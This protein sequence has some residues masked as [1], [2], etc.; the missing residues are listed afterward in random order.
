MRSTEMASPARAEELDKAAEQTIAQNRAHSPQ[1]VAAAYQAMYEQRGW[2]KLGPMPEAVTATLRDRDRTVLA[3]DGHTYTQGADRQWSTPGM[4]YGRDEAKGAVREELDATQ[5]MET[6]Q[7][8]QERPA[9]QQPLRLDDAA[10][11]DHALYLQAR[12]QVHQLDR[13]QGRTPDEGSDRMAAALTVAARAEGLQRI[14][15]IALSDDASK[16]WAAQGLDGMRDHFIRHASVD[17]AQAFRTPMEQSGAKWPEAM[18]QFQQ[19][20]QQSQAQNQAWEQTRQ[21]QQQAGHAPAM[22]R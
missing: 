9:S 19:I 16:L 13:Q 8:R 14:D 12:E 10:H 2:D 4:L 17:I 7:A 18:Q 11:P 15:K 3:S 20:Q 5:R 21:T 1:G 6:G 22:T